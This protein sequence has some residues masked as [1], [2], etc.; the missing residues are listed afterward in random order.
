MARGENA[1]QTRGVAR[2]AARPLRPRGEVVAG[3]FFRRS[4]GGGRGRGGGPW[5]GG[6]A[7]CRLGIYR[8]ARRFA[9]DA[10]GAACLRQSA[11]GGK[12][13]RQF[14]LARRLPHRADER[15][16][17]GL[18][19]VYRGPSRGSGCQYSPGQT[20]NKVPPGKSRARSAGPRRVGNTAQVPRSGSG[21]SHPSARQAAAGADAGAPA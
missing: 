3:R 8:R 16:L 1:G 9:G 11:A 4:A 17:P 2:T 19:P 13:R 18:L 10:G 7:V 14:C 12:S 21:P 20:G 5:G 15:P 6:G